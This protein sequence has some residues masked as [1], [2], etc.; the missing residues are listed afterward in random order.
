M[1]P[2]SRSL[3]NNLSITVSMRRTRLSMVRGESEDVRRMTA[4]DCV[5]KIPVLMPRQG[6]RTAVAGIARVESND[7][8]HA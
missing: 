6:S 8:K 2:Q 1:L 3:F 4:L 7:R 5:D